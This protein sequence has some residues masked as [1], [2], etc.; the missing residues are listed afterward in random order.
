MRHRG[1][2][3][4]DPVAG[5]E[6]VDGGGVDVGVRVEIEVPE[7]FVPGKVRCFDAADGGAPVPVVTLGQQQFRQEP[8]VGELFLSGDGQ[9]FVQHRPDRGQAQP[10][11]GLVHGCDRGLFGQAAPPAQGRSDGR[12]GCGWAHEMF[13]FDTVPA[14]YSVRLANSS[15]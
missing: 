4:A 11:A 8:L 9:G 14:G 7:P 3:L 2:S 13:S 6:G 15:S 10:A 1:A 5:G 12:R